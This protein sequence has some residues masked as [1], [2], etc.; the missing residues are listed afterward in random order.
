MLQTGTLEQCRIDEVICWKLG[1]N[2]L[3]K[4]SA[5]IV[6]QGSPMSW[7]PTVD[8]GSGL[9]EAEHLLVCFAGNN[10]YQAAKLSLN[11]FSLNSS[12]KSD[13]AHGRHINRVD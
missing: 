10:G 12:A 6:V 8:K 3:N 1:D 11:H 13:G 9:L 7:V 2:D 5:S 4:I